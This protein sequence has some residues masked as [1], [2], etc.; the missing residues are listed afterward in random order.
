MAT[1]IWAGILSVQLRTGLLSVSASLRSFLNSR[2]T[3]KDA[4]A[5]ANARNPMAILLALVTE[6]LKL[7]VLLWA[8]WT[9]LH[10]RGRRAVLESAGSVS[11]DGATTS[12]ATTKTDEQ[13]AK[14]VKPEHQ[15]TEV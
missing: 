12:A 10:R 2:P 3:L 7:A 8:V 1:L 11:V 5:L 9:A 15:G 6:G 4:T 14:S 13:V